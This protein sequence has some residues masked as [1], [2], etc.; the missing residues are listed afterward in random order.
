MGVRA[1]GHDGVRIGDAPWVASGF[2]H[3]GVRYATLADLVQTWERLL[4]A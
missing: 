4:A 2:E 3:V 1:R